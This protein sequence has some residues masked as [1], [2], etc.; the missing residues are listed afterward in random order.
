M[1]PSIHA[2]AAALSVLAVACAAP[3]EEAPGSAPEARAVDVAPTAARRTSECLA[4]RDARDPVTKAA[5]TWIVRVDLVSGEVRQGP[6]L[7]E[8]SSAIALGLRDATGGGAELVA[9]GA[10]IEVGS[11]L[12]SQV[13]GDCAALAE[14]A[15]AR[16]SVVPAG[17]RL[18]AASGGRLVV[19]GASRAETALV[20]DGTSGAELASLALATEDGEAREATGASLT[21]DGRLAILRPASLATHLV[22][23]DLDGRRERTLALPSEIHGLACDG[24]MSR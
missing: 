7:S 19:G 2:V 4:L 3:T 14:S 13:G 21:A 20:L 22:I 10:R 5:A 9:C 11:G 17:K 6:R 24:A 16:A 23:V 8:P 1:R 18:L 12:V 15:G